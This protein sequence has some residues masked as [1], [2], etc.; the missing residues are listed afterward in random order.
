M[1][2]RLQ[3]AVDILER[4]LAGDKRVTEKKVRAAEA[5]LR[6]ALPALRSCGEAKK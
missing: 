6:A 1:G 2:R 5:I 3:W 4:G